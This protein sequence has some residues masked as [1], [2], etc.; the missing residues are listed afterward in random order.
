MKVQWFHHCY[1]SKDLS[2]S[3]GQRAASLVEYALLLALISAISIG[4]VKATGDSLLVSLNEVS[5]AMAAEDTDAGGTPAFGDLPDEGG[6][7]E[8]D[9]EFGSGGMGAPAPPE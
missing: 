7:D 3:R 1:R 4:A 2:N 9:P 5:E 6:G 8:G